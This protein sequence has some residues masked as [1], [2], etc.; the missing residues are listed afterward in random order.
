MQ[1]LQ[2]LRLLSEGHESSY[3]EVVPLL[4]KLKDSKSNLVNN[5]IYTTARKLRQFVTPDSDAENY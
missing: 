2:D 3:V 5:A 1:L 4:D